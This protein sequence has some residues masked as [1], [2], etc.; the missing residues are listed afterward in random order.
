MSS[1]KVALLMGSK[2]DLP[3]LQNTVDTFK[4]FGVEAEV[5]VM[6]AHRTPDVVAE[7]ASSAA[8]RGIKIIICAAGGA[9]HLGGVVA[10]HTNLPVIG[11]PVP[12]G[13]LQGLDAL[14][15][16]VQMPGGIPVASVAVGMGGAKNA[17]LFAIQ[18]LALSDAGLAGKLKDFRVAQAEQVQAADNEVQQELSL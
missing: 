17:A 18:I 15:A 12:G 10:A 14:L 5:R 2:S 9:A 6:S 4:D 11:I 8:E 3:K 7:F 13:P 16:T 1:A